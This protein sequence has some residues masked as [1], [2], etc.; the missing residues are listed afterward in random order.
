MLSINSQAAA[1]INQVDDARIYYFD[2]HSDN[3]SNQLSV[4]MNL[5][6]RV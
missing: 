5:P 2:Q 4:I 3:I 6:N 1:V